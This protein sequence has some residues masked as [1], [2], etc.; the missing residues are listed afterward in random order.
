MG[1]FSMGVAI[2]DKISVQAEGEDEET[3]VT[4]LVDLLLNKLN[5]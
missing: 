2:G 3:A 1:I 5:N 4:E